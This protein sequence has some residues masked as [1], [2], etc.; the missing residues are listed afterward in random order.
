MTQLIQFEGS[1]TYGTKCHGCGNKS[2][3]DTKFLELEI[4]LTVRLT[5]D[6]P[7]FIDV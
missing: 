2:E 1:L 3:R 6:S 7:N 5:I 4:S